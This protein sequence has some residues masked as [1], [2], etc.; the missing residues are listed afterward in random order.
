M[1]G[2]NL[3]GEEEALECFKQKQGAFCLNFDQG[4]YIIHIENRLFMGKMQK[5]GHL[6]GIAEFTITCILTVRMSV[7]STEGIS[8]RILHVLIF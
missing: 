7:G 3:M 4:H 8:G 2:L 1:Q 6:G 5:A